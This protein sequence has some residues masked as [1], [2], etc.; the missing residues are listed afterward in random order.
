MLDI[1][2]SGQAV[3]WALQG[4]RRVAIIWSEG[5]GTQVIP[6]SGAYDETVASAINDGGTV[7]GWGKPTPDFV[8]NVAYPYRAMSNGGGGLFAA[9]DGLGSG[10][11]QAYD[12]NSN[13]DVAGVYEDPATG[14][15]HA[16]VRRNGAISNLNSRFL[17]LM[18]RDFSSGRAVGVTDSGIVAGVFDVGMYV[19]SPMTTYYRGFYLNATTGEYDYD[20]GTTFEPLPPRTFTYSDKGVGGFIQIDL[21][22]SSVPNGVG[23]L[24]PDRFWI[25]GDATSNI[26]ALPGPGQPTTS[27]REVRQPFLW[28]TEEFR[29]QFPWWS[30]PMINLHSRGSGSTNSN[31]SGRALNSA[32][33]SNT[34]QLVVCGSMEVGTDPEAVVWI[35]DPSRVDEESLEDIFA[36]DLSILGWANLESCTGFTR[37]SGR[38]WFIG[39]GE[40]ASGTRQAFVMR[41]QPPIPPQ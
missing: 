5:G 11:S 37:V 7:V 33:D 2:D 24:S 26:T 16:F 40:R 17:N 31:D 32:W 39:V 22:G 1:N 29:A 3:G 14:T 13:G 4:G 28:G 25:Y 6:T 38:E 34:A 19:G 12:V 10:H 41:R 27:V 9:I 35:L 21:R 8:N 23:S 18:G 30:T 36:A 15:R 20:I